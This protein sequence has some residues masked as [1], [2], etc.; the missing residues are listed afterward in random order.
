MVD[1]SDRAVPVAPNPEGFKNCSS[2]YGGKLIEHEAQP[3]ALLCI[4]MP[5]V[6]E[7]KRVR[8]LK[9]RKTILMSAW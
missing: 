3:S 6:Y 8:Y 5:V 9:K 4:E 1:N 7:H 2:H